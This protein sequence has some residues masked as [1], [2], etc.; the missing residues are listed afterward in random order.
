MKTLQI[1]IFSLIFTLFYSCKNNASILSE[2][3]QLKRKWRL[4]EFEPFTKIQLKENHAY[5]DLSPNTENL[6]YRMG[7]NTINIQLIKINQQTFRIVDK[8]STGNFCKNME[9]EF[10]FQ[11]FASNDVI[12]SIENH[13]LTL[14]TKDGNIAKFVAEDWD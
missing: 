12:Y 9:L 7:C 10:A 11:K 5:L 13:F 3:S 8:S 6:E 2:N 4:V 1:I 14:K